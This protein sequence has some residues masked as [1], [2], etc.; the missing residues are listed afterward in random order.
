[1]GLDI[2]RF[3]ELPTEL[4]RSGDEAGLFQLNRIILK[5]CESDV[6]QRHPSA[7]ALRDE[8]IALQ[9]QNRRETRV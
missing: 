4:V 1:M 6:R 2:T 9:K 8:L 7:A 3:T 5:A